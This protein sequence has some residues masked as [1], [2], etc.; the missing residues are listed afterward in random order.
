MKSKSLSYLLVFAMALTISAVGCR[1]KPV[2]TTRLP[3]DRVGV[4]GDK[5]ADTSGTYDP[6]TDPNRVGTPLPTDID[7]DKMEQNR[8]ELAANTVHFDYDSAAVKSSER[9]HVE[10]V[11]S[12]MKST[13]GVALLVEGHCDE[14]GTEEY[15]RALGERRALSLREALIAAG[16]DGMKIVTRTYGK[17]RK[18]DFG[19]SEAAH[20][21]NRRGEFVVLRPK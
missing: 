12:F 9:V 1:K 17:D 6:N 14:R 21:K 3:G 2:N 16:A 18:V 15:N 4:G 10:A 20:A 19:T 5:P 7:P 8:A 13:G 11:A